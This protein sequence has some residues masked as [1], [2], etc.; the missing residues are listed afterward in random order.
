MPQ[1]YSL[2]VAEVSRETADAV[3]VVFAVPAELAD[4]FT[5][6][7]GQHLTLRREFDG[8]EERRNYSICS[9]VK[10]AELRVAIK[11]LPG[12][13]F[14]GFVNAQLTVDTALDVMPPSGR[15]YTELDPDQTC[16]YLAFAAGSGITPILS[17]LKTTLETEQQSRF[18]L[19]YGNRS[20]RNIMFLEELNDLKD[21]YPTRFSLIHILSRE[22]QEIELFSGHID[23]AKTNELLT[24]LIPANTID[25]CFICGPQAMIET[26]S[27]TLQQ[28]GLDQAQIHFELF[29]TPG[30]STPDST[31]VN[32]TR[33][34]ERRSSCSPEPGHSHSRWQTYRT[35]APTWR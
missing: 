31:A 13:K 28:H 16:H 3:T 6:I 7:Q 21:R 26:V 5:Y 30:V 1:F 12:G 4:E 22:S 32:N 14:S 18:T 35:K 2:R 10:D 24:T 29:T 8:V 23:A 20:T 19:V 25:Q 9:S 27:E 34:P 11:H 33:Q 17:I 15:F